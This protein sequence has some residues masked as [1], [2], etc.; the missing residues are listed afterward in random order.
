MNLK[1]IFAMGA[2]AASTLVAVAPANAVVTVFANFSNVGN[3]NNIRWVASANT[4]AGNFSRN[5]TFF[6]IANAGSNVPGLRATNFTFSQPA[7]AGV[8]PLLASMTLDGTVTNTIATV[9]GAQIT[10]TN[11][12][13]SFSFIQTSPI[14]TIGQSSFG[15]GANLLSGTFTQSTINGQRAGTSAGWS[16]STLGGSNIMF[17]S[18]ILGFVPGSNFDLG[19]SLASIVPTL[20]ALAANNGV[21]NPPNKALRTFKSVLGGQFSSDPAPL[22]PTIPEPASWMLMII[23]F[24]MVAISVRNRSRQTSVSA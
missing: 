24:G 17:T 12:S 5:A 20:N 9:N 14:F 22:T 15:P 4:A 2:I 19:W 21:I 6:S 13:G 3:T 1:K 23:G 10:Q 11:V 16:A 7:L 18:A 8:G